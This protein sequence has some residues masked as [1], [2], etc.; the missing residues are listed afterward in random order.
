MTL[1]H[2]LSSAFREF[3]AGVQHAISLHR[4]LLFYI[5]SRLICVSSAK[6]RRVTLALAMTADR[7]EEASQLAS[8]LS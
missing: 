6:V 7:I 8:C 1:E 5:N 2:V 4:I 3:C